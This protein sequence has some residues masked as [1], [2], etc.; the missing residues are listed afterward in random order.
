MRFYHWNFLFRYHSDK[1]TTCLCSHESR[2]AFPNVRVLDWNLDFLIN[3]VSFCCKR[4]DNERFGNVPRY[5][6]IFRNIWSLSQLAKGRT[7]WVKDRN[8]LHSVNM[9]GINLFDF[10]VSSLIVVVLDSYLYK[11]NK[12]VLTILQLFV[13][14]TLKSNVRLQKYFHSF[15]HR[16]W[17]NFMKMFIFQFLPTNSR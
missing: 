10:Y 12:V 5:F 4:K 7:W 16:I 1:L 6:A 13:N 17:R 15:V 8:Y 3:F 11:N 14:V 9:K 2:E